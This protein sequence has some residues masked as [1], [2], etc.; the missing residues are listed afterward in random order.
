MSRPLI[1]LCILIYSC[2]TLTNETVDVNNL[3]NLNFENPNHLQSSGWG[4][5]YH[6]NWSIDS[7]ESRNGKY[8]LRIDPDTLSRA[9]WIVSMHI[10]ILEETRSI[11]IECHTKKIGSG[12]DSLALKVEAYLGKNIKRS[13]E[14]V[15]IFAV[16]SNDGWQ[17]RSTKLVLDTIYDFVMFGIGTNNGDFLIDDFEVKLNGI[18]LTDCFSVSSEDIHELNKHS[19]PIESKELNEAN[20]EFDFLT[21]FIGNAKAIGLGESTHG[22]REIFQT[23]NRII[24]HLIENEGFNTIIFEGGMESHF[25]INNMLEENESIDSIMNNLFGIYQTEEI[26][27]LFEWVR[28]KNQNQAQSI[29][30]W[31]CDMQDDTYNVRALVEFAEQYDKA[32]LNKI[33]AYEEEYKVYESLAL[34]DSLLSHVNKKR[35]DYLTKVTEEKLRKL[36][37]NIDLLKQYI[38]FDANIGSN[39]GVHR[40]SSMANNISWIFDSYPKTKAIV[41]A[42]NS[43]I[44]KIQ[45]ENM[46]GFLEKNLGEEYFNIGF[47]LNKGNYRAK[48]NGKYEDCVLN[49]PFLNSYEYYLSMADTP[50]YYLPTNRVEGNLEWHNKRLASTFRGVG[51]TCNDHQFWKC[52]DVFKTFDA[53]IYIENSISAKGLYK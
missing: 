41:W 43:H 34:V 12:V 6:D 53:L 51:H 10:P 24:K 18:P 36:L 13:G 8:A 1:L 31:G 15:S 40:D 47:A 25:A 22:T 37:K 3:L 35:E 46:G 2:S 30:I 28:E 42:H 9:Q 7:T 19:I 32:L 11:E 26:K 33:T 14:S 29:K 44:S 39:R 5:D 27:E 23:K 52:A 48:R 50:I 4:T 20:S 17:S 38:Y 45:D 49:F 16:K 21:D